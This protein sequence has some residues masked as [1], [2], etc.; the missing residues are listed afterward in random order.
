MVANKPS[1]II[2]WPPEIAPEN[3]AHLII[4]FDLKDGGLIIHF[5]DGPFVRGKTYTMAHRLNRDVVDKMIAFLK[6]HRLAASV[7]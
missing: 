1:L 2:Q 5:G 4:S 3:P 6:E 7:D